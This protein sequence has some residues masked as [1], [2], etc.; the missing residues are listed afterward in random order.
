MANTVLIDADILAFQVAT[1]AETPTQFPDDIWVLWADGKQAIQSVDDGINAIMT[2]TSAADYRLCLTG[3][4][5]FR[6]RVSDTYKS[7]RSGKRKPMILSYLRD[8]MLDKHDAIQYDT[9]EGDDVIGILATGEFKDNHIIYSA[10]K[11]LK[12][13]TGNHY[14][15][16]FE[17]FIEPH[18]AERYFYAQVLTGDTTDGYKGCPSVGPVKADRILDADP[19]WSSVVEA[20]EKAGLTEQDAI[21]QAR[22]AYILHAKDWVNNKVVLWNPPEK[23][24]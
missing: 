5:N 14:D 8:Y 12:T 6:Y 19:S 18:E 4:N 23:G 1:A 11:D 22:Q 3:K 17:R 10:D 16:G 7:N 24:A 2:M 15:D 20:Y 21:V 13:V 9:L